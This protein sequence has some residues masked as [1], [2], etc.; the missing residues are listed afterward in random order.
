MA[1]IAIRVS[2]T[3]GDRRVSKTFRDTDA[4]RRAARAFAASLKDTTTAYDVRTR[5]DDRVVTKTHRSRR[6]AAAY[7]VT[8]EA[9]KLQ[10]AAIDPK[11]A[12]VTVK[13]YGTDWLAKRTDLAATT[14]SLYRHLFDHHIVPVLGST[15]VGNLSMAR[16]KSWHAAIDKDQPTTAAKAYRLLATIMRSAIDDRLIVQSPCR[17]K[18]AAAES[19]PERPVV[20]MA[21][22]Q[23]LADAMPNKLRLAVLLAAS[24]QLRRGELLGLRRKDVDELHQELSVEITR[25]ATV[26]GDE[27]TKGP[28]TEA[29]KREIVIPSNLASDISDHMKHFVASDA[30]ARI[31]DVDTREL[32]RAWDRARS[33]VGLPKLHMHDLRHSGLTW[34]AATGATVAELMHRAGHRSPTAAMRYQHAT[35]DRDKALA[36]ALAKL[37]PVAKVTPM[38][39]RR[40]S[41]G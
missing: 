39:R 5:V 13:D 8:I 15:A 22:V 37:A 33:V 10:G 20:S 2:G 12:K 24:C 29:G 11:R 18:G 40:R 26:D 6:D 27:V 35:K 41:A 34:S 14:L 4:G 38:R 1:Q 30:T 23:A 17:V 21:E 7:A 28:K 32:R 3:E 25:T 9:E 16:V 36:D 31:F 19:A